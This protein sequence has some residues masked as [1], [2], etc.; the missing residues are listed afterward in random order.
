LHVPFTICSSAWAF[1]IGQLDDR[2]L[3]NVH[4]S[5]QMHPSLSSSA[6]LQPDVKALHIVAFR[7][8][9]QQFHIQR[10]PRSVHSSMVMWHE[11]APWVGT[12]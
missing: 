8:G 11:H 9:L 7:E 2:P 6:T 10:P 3:A 1:V 12:W 5:W 4:G